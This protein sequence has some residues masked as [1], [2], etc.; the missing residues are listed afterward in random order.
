MIFIERV[1]IITDKK[2]CEMTLIEIATFATLFISSIALIR[3]I[4]DKRFDKLEQDL[5]KRLGRI[6]VDI[7]DL[8]G[9]VKELGHDI[10]ELKERVAGIEMSTIFLQV[11]PD[12]P[13]RSEI[14]KKMWERRKAKQVEKK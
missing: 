11:N 3:T 14:A 1:S 4:W 13:S 7:K 9:D 6:E 12:P 8:R 5:D 2:E 10:S